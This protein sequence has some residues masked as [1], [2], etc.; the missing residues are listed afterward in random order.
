MSGGCKCCPISVKQNLKTKAI[1][2]FLNAT[3]LS[4]INLYTYFYT[5]FRREGVFLHPERPASHGLGNDNFS[6]SS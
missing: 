1:W 6:D 3:V 5:L 4:L 2:V